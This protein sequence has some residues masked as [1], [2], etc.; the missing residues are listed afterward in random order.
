MVL[1]ICAAG[2]GQSAFRASV[3]KVAAQGQ[4]RQS[5]RRKAAEPRDEYDRTPLMRAASRGDLTSAKELVAKGAD[6][7]AATAGGYTSLMSAAFEGNANMVKLL[8]ENG[9]AL[10]ASDDHGLTALI[11]AAKQYMDHGDVIAEYVGTVEALLKVGAD[12]SPRDMTGS[13]ALMYVEKYG[14]RNKQEI[15]RLLTDA[16]ARQ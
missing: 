13:T 5:D 11:E 7:N 8:L 1:W 9:A 4:A 10:N 15:V 12:V 2:V 6:V 14:L 16:G 3:Q